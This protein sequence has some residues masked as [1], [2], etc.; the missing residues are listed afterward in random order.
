MTTWKEPV[1]SFKKKIELYDPLPDISFQ[2]LEQNSK[3]LVSREPKGQIVYQ[4]K[5][6]NYQIG[7]QVIRFIKF[8]QIAL[9]KHPRILVRLH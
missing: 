6:Y 3:D 9:I 5:L 1:F 2:N 4:A 7:R 8:H